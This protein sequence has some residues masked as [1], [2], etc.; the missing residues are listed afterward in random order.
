MAYKYIDPVAQSFIVTTPCILTKVG[1][2]FTG[3]A[4]SIPAFVHLRSMVNGY[5]GSYII[6]F[7]EK[8]I[9]P[10]S[11]TLS[12]NSTLNENTVEFNSPIFL[13]KGEYALCVG[14]PSN[15]WTTCVSRVGARDNITRKN[16]NLQPYVGSLFKSQNASTWTAEQEVDLTFKLYR[17][18]FDTSAAASVEFKID[19]SQN[20]SVLLDND[21]LEVVSGSNLLRI[22]HTDHG[23]ADG[24]HI[25]LRGLGSVSRLDGTTVYGIDWLD[26]TTDFGGTEATTPLAISNVA[27]NSYTVTLPS[28]A[29]S[30]ARF[31]GTTVKVT[32][33]I[34]VDAIQPII[35]K[36]EQAG[37]T[38]INRIKLVN[39]AGT[40]DSA[41]KVISDDVTELTSPRIIPS[42]VI[43]TEN[44]AAEISFTTS[45]STTDKYLSPI[46][47]T[48]QLGLV[49][50]SNLLNNPSYA[51]ENNLAAFDETTILSSVSTAFTQDAGAYGNIAI[52]AGQ[53]PA[54]AA[55]T[56]GTQLTVT[57]G[58]NAGSYRITDIEEDGSIVYV[59][60]IAGSAITT[61]TTSITVV[62]GD[63]YI[64]EEAAAGGTVASRYITRQVDFLNPCT[65]FNI[66]VLT[67]RAQGSNIDFYYKVKSVGEAID[68]KDKEFVPLAVTVP[69]SL[70][71]RFE[72]VEYQ[73]DTA[74]PLPEFESIILKI[75][76]TSTDT[77]RIPK[78]KNL[79]LIALA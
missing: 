14:S 8:V 2:Y 68:L 53:R 60:N 12:T 30:S 17:A 13:D 57:G 6:P 33:N 34:R 23:M 63:K 29:T 44:S 40:Q 21:P 36:I 77:T 47:D 72:E 4:A 71:G 25:L 18:V 20:D 7:S 62:N 11:V 51:T 5:P 19:P 55:M 35:S 41:Y 73:V 66:R 76:F 48:K 43:N 70:D 24:D 67:S 42:E 79:R 49:A 50:A 46:I 56:V 45:L 59:A 69:V 64:S 52:P 3:K 39:S 61:Q 74:S 75:V 26:Y 58:S 54:A 10:S 78:C 65:T 37:T 38:S 27:T 28:N 32:R 1:L 15:D 16:I 31:G 22:Y 9:S